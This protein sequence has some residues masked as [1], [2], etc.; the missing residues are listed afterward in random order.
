VIEELEAD[1]QGFTTVNKLYEKIWEEFGEIN[2]ESMK[3][4]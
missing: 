1:I 3:V 2:K 4:Y